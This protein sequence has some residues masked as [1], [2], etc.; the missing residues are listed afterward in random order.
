M[1]LEINDM[2]YHIRL[3]LETERNM[4]FKYIIDK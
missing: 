3:I 1:S 4:Q 2:M